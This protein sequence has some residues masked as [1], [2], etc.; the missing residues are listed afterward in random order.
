LWEDHDV[1]VSKSVVR[2]LL[3]KHGYR[4]R[5]AQ[6]KRTMKQVAHRNAIQWT[7]FDKKVPFPHIGIFNRQTK[8]TNPRG[9]RH[10]G[11]GRKDTQ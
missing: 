1:R 4:R 7:F 9:K 8:E 6:K 3:K 2:Q 11:L 5:K 10:H